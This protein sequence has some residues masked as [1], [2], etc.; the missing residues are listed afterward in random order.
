MRDRWGHAIACRS[1][2]EMAAQACAYGAECF[3]GY[4]ISLRVE[5]DPDELP[6]DVEPLVADLVTR[7]T[8]NLASGIRDERRLRADVAAIA[9]EIADWCMKNPERS[10]DLYLET[11]AHQLVA[12]LVYR[13]S[14]TS[15]GK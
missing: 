7:T 2:T 15:P 12:R 4:D 14:E 6:D 9:E 13:P 8:R 3:V 1:G 10:R 11:T 5:W